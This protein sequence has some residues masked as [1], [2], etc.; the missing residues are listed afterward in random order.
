[1]NVTDIR[2]PVPT[3]YGDFLKRFGDL[4]KEQIAT[5]RKQFKIEETFFP[6]E[7]PTDIP[8]VYVPAENI[9]EVMRFL[10]TTKGFEYSFFTDMTATDE[11]PRKPRFDLIYQL[12]S[13]EQPFSRI[14]IKV[15]VQENQKVDTLCDVWPSANWAE[16]EVYDMFGVEFKGHPDLRRIL[17]DHR[18]KG[19]PLRKDYP[20]RG[21]Q[22][23]PTPEDIDIN[24]LK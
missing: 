19:H 7:S 13:P 12:M 4:W 20:L 5:L 16:R 21:Y 17:M 8:I 18:W 22:V 9:V 14:R 10:K 2:T 6:G 23:F 15:K 3:I 1:M 11:T 24:L